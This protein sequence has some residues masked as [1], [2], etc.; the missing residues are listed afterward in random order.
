MFEIP[1]AVMKAP[2]SSHMM[3]AATTAEVG[4]LLLGL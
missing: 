4:R 2:H 3:I 1:P